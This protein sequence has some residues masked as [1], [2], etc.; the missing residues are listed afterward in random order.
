MG[1]IVRDGYSLPVQL[2]IILGFSVVTYVVVEVPVVSY[3]VAPDITAGRVDAFSQW[4]KTN[5]IQVVAVLA[6]IVGIALI[7]KGLTAP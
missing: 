4:L 5:K 6:G 3:L 1:Q 7:I 2:L